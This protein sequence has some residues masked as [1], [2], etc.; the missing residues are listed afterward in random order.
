MI[1]D[2]A[3]AHG[4]KPHPNSTAVAWSFYHNK[5]IHGEEGGAVWFREPKHA[6][7]ARQLRSLGFTDSHDFIHIPRGHNYRMSNCH[8]ELILPSL[9]EADYNIQ[10][11]KVS[12]Q[13]YNEFTPKEWRMPARDVPWVY[14]LRIPDLT[15]QTQW[16]LV[17]NL[18]EQGVA[19]RCGFRCMAEQPEF[20][21]FY[22]QTNAY[23]LSKEVFYLPLRPWMEAKEIR[24]T[25]DLLIDWFNLV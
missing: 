9:R 20:R 25:V 7:K 24:R 21:G 18:N 23:R 17:Q 8:A 5:I 15:H 13:I 16:K 2:L 6:D 11:R 14:D 10:G 4:V 1:E 3:E 22:E 12:E 19:A